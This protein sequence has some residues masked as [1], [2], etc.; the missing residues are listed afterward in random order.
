[1]YWRRLLPG[2]HRRQGEVPRDP[3]SLVTKG[4]GIFCSGPSS[5]ILIGQ[6]VLQ[7]DPHSGLHAQGLL[8]GAKDGWSFF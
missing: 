6:P 5:A 2:I 4:R 8:R 7:R 3:C 1:M